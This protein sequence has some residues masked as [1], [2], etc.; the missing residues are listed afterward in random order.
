MKSVKITVPVSEEDINDL[1]DGK[2]VEWTFAYKEENVTV[3]FLL[4]EDQGDECFGI[5]EVEAGK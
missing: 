1:L 5:K 3:A 2:L 4:S